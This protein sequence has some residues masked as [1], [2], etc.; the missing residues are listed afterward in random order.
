MST[1]PP[2]FFFNNDSATVGTEAKTRKHTRPQVAQTSRI[3]QTQHLC[4]ST[5][6]TYCMC[7]SHYRLYVAEFSSLPGWKTTGDKERKRSAMRRAFAALPSTLYGL[8]SP[9][10]NGDNT[11]S[12]PRKSNGK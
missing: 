10:A 5:T 7:V 8:A 1:P 2:H 12:K 9:Y 11:N 4:E 3:A 6:D